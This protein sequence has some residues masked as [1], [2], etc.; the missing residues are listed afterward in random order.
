M[1]GP[2]RRRLQ[3]HGIVQGVGFRPFVWRLANELRLAG[4]VRNDAAGVTIEAEGPPP[5]LDAF[6][7]RLHS[8]APARARVDEVLEQV[9][10]PMAP[11]LATNDARAAG[12]RP[13]T[14]GFAI[15]ASAGGPAAT[16]IG[17]DTALCDD[18][19]AELLDPADRRWRYPFVNCTNCGPRF[20]ITRALPYDRA[21]TSMA[22]F[23]LCPQCR[24]IGRAHV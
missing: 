13:S 1:D 4:W 7:R 16:A 2:Q 24:E 20:T 5:A 8:D 12:I 21:L 3:V 15:L 9:L 23:A 17:P 14:E 18:C 11:A 10:P 19:L 6:A 22:G